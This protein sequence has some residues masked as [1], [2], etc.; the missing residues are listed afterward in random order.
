MAVGGQQILTGTLKTKE[1]TIEC[2]EMRITEYGASSS[3]L[4]TLWAAFARRFNEFLIRTTLDFLTFGLRAA[5]ITARA[6]A[7]PTGIQRPGLIIL[8]DDIII[9]AL[10]AHFSAHTP[11]TAAVHLLVH[12]RTLQNGTSAPFTD[13][14]SVEACAIRAA[15]GHEFHFV[16]VHF[17]TKDTF[18]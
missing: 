6:T 15:V 2:L 14:R 5:Y 17:V 7:R 3:R 1:F 18:P 11:R 13:R 8:I 10:G 16:H 9:H 12:L 4:D